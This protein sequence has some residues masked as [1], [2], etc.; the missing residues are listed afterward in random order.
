MSEIYIKTSIGDSIDRLTILNIKCEKLN[1]KDKLIEVNREK[2]ILINELNKYLQ[3]DTVYYYYTILEKIN[4][5]IWE[6]LDNAKYNSKD[7]NSELEYY[8][9][10]EDYN[11]RRFRVKRMIDNY[12]KSLIKEQK[13]YKL[14]QCYILTHLGLGDHIYHDGMIRYLTTI[15]DIVHI[16]CFQSNVNNLTLLFTDILNIIKFVPVNDYDH[17]NHYKEIE[18]IK[19]YT[20]QNNI[21]EYFTGSYRRDKQDQ[22]Y[23]YPFSW[24]DLV[25]ID[26]SVFWDYSYIPKPTKCSEIYSLVED[27]DYAFIHNTCSGGKVFNTNLVEKTFN[28]NRDNVLIINPCVN[29]YNQEHKF[30]NVADKFLKFKLLEYITVIENANYIMLSDSSFFG[31]AHHLKIKTDNKYY[32]HRGLDYQHL[33]NDKYKSKNINSPVFKKINVDN[34]S[35]IPGPYKPH[36]EGGSSIVKHNV[37]N[38]N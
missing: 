30:Y 20:T 36:I 18:N 14:K 15:Y 13:G 22:I 32:F 9:E 24:Y 31:L 35:I 38:E 7:K 8:R 6:L 27:M 11:E 25:N 12:N 19:K 26:C 1:D 28:I 33:Y 21:D 3:E 17:P 2:D 5:H 29:I 16:V 23:D 4:K 34:I 37:L 10:Q